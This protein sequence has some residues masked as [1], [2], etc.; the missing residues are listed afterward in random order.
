M[1]NDLILNPHTPK[2]RE[3]NTKASVNTNSNS[4]RDMFM[5]F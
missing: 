2:A 3:T 4:F 1:L 5:A